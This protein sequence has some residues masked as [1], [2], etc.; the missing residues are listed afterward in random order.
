MKNQAL[1]PTV[2]GL[3][4]TENQEINLETLS[5]SAIDQLA[6]GGFKPSRPIEHHEF[7]K[8][9]K[10]NLTKEF[11][12]DVIIEP[13]AISKNHAKRINFKGK[14]DEMCPINQVLITRL[15]TRFF[16][17]T[18]TKYLNEHELIPS[19]A[20]AYS[21]EG[22]QVAMGTNV[23]AC[24]NMNIFGE[25]FYAT[26][27]SNKLSFDNLKLIIKEKIKSISE[28][29]EENYKT[30]K[31]LDSKILPSI[32]IRIITNKLFEKAVDA[33]ANRNNKSSI[34]NVSQV[35]KMQEEILKKKDRI[36]EGQFT[37][38]DLTQAGTENLK[39][40]TNDMLM[41]YPTIKKFNNFIE[42][43]IMN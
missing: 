2:N 26:Y 40:M 29:Q 21:E 17:P 4:F 24:S 16:I 20:I 3:S 25:N 8:W 30:I 14:P 15:V 18:H 34:L 9:I 10:Y 23:R 7:I 31:Y 32:G 27:G 1:I 22:I 39:P 19:I 28:L 42:T 11:G 5:M 37:A 38:W 36:L 35:I 12:N 13:I 43:E 41:L 6:T 33:N